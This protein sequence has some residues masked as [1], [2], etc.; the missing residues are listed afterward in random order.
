MREDEESG[1]RRCAG[2]EDLQEHNGQNHGEED[3][4]GGSLSKTPEARTR[5][6]ELGGAF[7]HDHKRRIARG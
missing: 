6:S 2:P 1:G 4:K 5:R 3:R 7:S